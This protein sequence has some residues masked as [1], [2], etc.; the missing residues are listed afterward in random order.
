M[1]C[2]IH[3][4]GEVKIE[5]LWQHYSLPRIS[6]NY[7]L[8]AKMANV[9]NYNESNIV[10]ISEP[11]GLPSDISFVTWFDYMHC[12]KEY[13][14]SMSW[15]GGEELDILENWMREYGPERSK[16]ERLFNFGDEF[17]YVFGNSWNIKKYPDD[18]PLGVQD[19]RLVF[20]FD[21]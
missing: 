1:G 14:H 11:K 12:W 19:A 6:R 8:F 7:S 13:G 4:H 16:A 2:D 17:G 18:Y 10:P 20:W 15:L 5:G 9:R 3:I 21:S